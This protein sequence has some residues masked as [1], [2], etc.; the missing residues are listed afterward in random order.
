MDLQ[1]LF[2]SEKLAMLLLVSLSGI[3]LINILILPKF[4]FLFHH[5]ALGSMEY[6]HM[7][8]EQNQS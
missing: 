3:P 8:G 6:M 1:Q 2:V 5:F 4:N 7:Y